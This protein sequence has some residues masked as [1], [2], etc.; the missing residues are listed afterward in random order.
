MKI[1]TNYNQ[2]PQLTIFTV[3]GEIDFH[4][5]LSSINNTFA[6]SDQINGFLWD[7]RFAEGGQQISLPQIAQ[8]YS[9]YSK[10]VYNVPSRFFAFLVNEEIG[11]GLAQV[12]STFEELYDVYLNVKVFKH[13]DQALA[14]LKQKPDCS[15]LP[16]IALS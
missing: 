5:L 13:Y 16:G 12:M 14:W 8:F 1:E 15:G 6:A 7:L 11:F 9:L 4:A 2:P 10:Y 3:K